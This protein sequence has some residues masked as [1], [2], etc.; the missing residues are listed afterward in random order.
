M[1]QKPKIRVIYTDE[2]I[3]FL[4]E[5]PLPVRKKINFN[6]KKVEAGIIDTT[7]FKK[8]DS[9]DLW[10]FR[11]LYGG[12]AYRVLAFWD[13]ETE[14]LIVACN[15]FIKKTP[16]TPSKEIAKANEARKDWFNEKNK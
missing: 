11:T 3:K 13:T 4:S 14:T 7:I 8:L 6:I 15:G 12:I 10:E 2:A 5:L 1:E 9:T 16:R